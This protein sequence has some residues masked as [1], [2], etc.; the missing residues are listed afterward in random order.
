MIW[1]GRD[2]TLILLTGGYCFTWD[3]PVFCTSLIRALIYAISINFHILCMCSSWNSVFCSRSPCWS[4][5]A[6]WHRFLSQK[7]HRCETTSETQGVVV[8]FWKIS[9][10]ETVV[11]DDENHHAAASTDAVNCPTLKSGLIC[12][13]A[14]EPRV[15]SSLNWASVIQLNGV[16]M[17]NAPA[18]SHTPAR[19]YSTQVI[20]YQGLGRYFHLSLGYAVRRQSLGVRGQSLGSANNG[21][22]LF[23]G[24]KAAAVHVKGHDGQIE[25]TLF[26]RQAAYFPG[27]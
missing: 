11:L 2:H 1:N 16:F 10:C 15:K 21:G 7:K 14:P 3:C 23:C 18:P 25:R 6:A 12:G 20:S 27:M 5:H 17:W 24:A 26:E 4:T 22:V 13:A 9:R 8:P 19:I